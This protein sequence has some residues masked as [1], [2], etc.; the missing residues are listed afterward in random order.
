M[1]PDQDPQGSGTFDPGPELLFRIQVSNR[2]I[3]AFI[4]RDESHF[5]DPKVN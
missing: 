5:A 4:K 1:D 2:E 3:L